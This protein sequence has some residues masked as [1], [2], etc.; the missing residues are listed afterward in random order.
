MIQ[1]QVDGVSILK[2]RNFD[3]FSGINHGIFM[4]EG[5]ISPAPYKSLN[6][7]L[8][9]GD[10]EGNV[11]GNRSII[12]KSMEKKDILF[13]HQVHGARILIFNRENGIV[14]VVDKTVNLKRGNCETKENHNFSFDIN[15]EKKIIGDA[16]IT[17]KKDFFLGVQVADC[18][19][20][21]L[22]DPVQKVVANVHVGWRGSVAN[23]LKYTVSVMEEYFSCFPVDMVAGICPSLG[24]CC[25][26]FVRYKEEI[27]RRF[28]KYKDDRDHF[29]FWS[30][31]RDQLS[32]SG[33]RN[34]NISISR[35]CTKCNTN[36]F[37]SYRKEKTTGR[38]AAV[39]GL[40]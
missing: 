18:Q 27:P 36:L 17:N 2:F 26:E 23:L 38:F 32:D 33:I 21:L 35:I 31:S 7:G 15:D 19:A 3:R 5:G 24:P 14:K 37:Y 6:V 25:A 28:W 10:D 12:S 34:E 20:V 39:I 4:R 8:G 29:D 9:V 22:Y 13:V 16:L 11:L 30:I 40:E 1:K